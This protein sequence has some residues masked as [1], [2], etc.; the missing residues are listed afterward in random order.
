MTTISL[1][2]KYWT[3]SHITGGDGRLLE[4]IVD[5][6]KRPA[7]TPDPNIAYKWLMRQGFKPATFMWLD[8]PGGLSRRR[9]Q[10]YKKGG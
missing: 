2:I 3:P 7:K 4:V 5:G 6:E 8:R 10:T 1:V 9:R